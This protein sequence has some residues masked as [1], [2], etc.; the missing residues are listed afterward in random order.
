M[1]QCDLHNVSTLRKCNKIDSKQLNLCYIFGIIYTVF[2][3]TYLNL[4]K[5][6]KG[7]EK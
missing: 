5:K 1:F 3:G 2:L 4:L 7:G 6:K